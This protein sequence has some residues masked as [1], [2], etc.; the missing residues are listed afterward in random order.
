MSHTATD[1]QLCQ[2]KGCLHREARR[3]LGWGLGTGLVFWYCDGCY[4]AALARLARL[5]E[6]AATWK[7][8]RN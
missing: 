4:L 7:H 5:L 2:A 3:G 8:W 6:A 1:L